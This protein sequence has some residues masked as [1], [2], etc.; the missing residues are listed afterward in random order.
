[1]FLPPFPRGLCGKR[2]HVVAEVPVYAV[3][4]G[5]SLSAAFILQIFLSGF[6]FVAYKTKTNVSHGGSEIRRHGRHRQWWWVTSRVGREVHER[7]LGLLC[8]VSVISVVVLPVNTK[9]SVIMKSASATKSHI[10][11]ISLWLTQLV[12]CTSLNKLISALLAWN[13]LVYRAHIRTYLTWNVW[14]RMWL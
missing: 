12:S 7:W 1:M 14:I 5:H 3:Q 13:D 10:S 9:M 6:V 11:V 2:H 8:K 4:G